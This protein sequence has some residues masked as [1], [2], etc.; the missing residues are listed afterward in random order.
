MNK[1]ENY[2]FKKNNSGTPF[3]DKQKSK[4]SKTEWAGMS[5]KQLFHAIERAE[6]QY[7]KDIHSKIPRDQAK[8][9][10]DMLSEIVHKIDQEPSNDIGDLR[11][12]LHG[13][14]DRID[15]VMHRTFMNPSE[16]EFRLLQNLERLKT[17]F[18]Y[19]D[20]AEPQELHHSNI[21]TLNSLPGNGKVMEGMTQ[22]RVLEQVQDGTGSGGENCGFHALKNSLLMLSENDPNQLHLLFNDRDV[23]LKFYNTY[24]LPFVKEKVIGSRDATQP[25]L[26]DILQ[27]EPASFK[28]PFADPIGAI[29]QDP[30]TKNKI[31]IFQMSTT[32]GGSDGVPVLGFTGN[33]QALDGLKLVRFAK[34]PG[35]S[36]LTM[37]FGDEM[38]GHWYALQVNKDALNEISFIGSDSM[39]NHHEIFGDRSA[40]GQ[41]AALIKGHIENSEDLLKSI[42]AYV[43]DSLSIYSGWFAPDQTIEQSNALALLDDTPNLLL[44]SEESPKGSKKEMILSNCLTAYKIIQ[45]GNW[46]FSSDLWIYERIS[47]L[48]VLVNFYIS[49]LPINDPYVPKLQEIRREIQFQKNGNIISEIIE[50]AVADI[51]QKRT[52]LSARDCDQVSSVFTHL[53]T[54]Y[55]ERKQL[56]KI[57][58]KT[59]RENAMNLLV[60]GGIEPGF[61]TGTTPNEAERSLTHKIHMVLLTYQKAK[62]LNRLDDLMKKIYQGDVCLTARVGRI[63]EFQAELEGM[64]MNEDEGPAG[65]LNDGPMLAISEFL[66][67]LTEESSDPIEDVKNV[68][69]NEIRQLADLQSLANQFATYC[70]GY[71]AAP[72][73]HLLKKQG[74]ISDI[75]NIDWIDA[76]SKIIKRPEFSIWFELGKAQAIHDLNL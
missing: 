3:F 44:A 21:E 57:Q 54:L 61:A 74:V 36:S 37:I 62:K 72:L 35:P 59:K 50:N 1:Y 19:V 18:H 69:I 31:A 45:E 76:V 9:I 34:Q 53:L 64:R 63:E 39:D 13:K 67:Q 52:Q 26:R 66:Q 4:N 58:D 70:S 71:Q 33:F 55:T 6:N 7:I 68:Q 51:N 27:Q 41:L 24:C 30:G 60:P 29:L 16:E 11:S 42:Y 40:F 49:R 56:S 12:I 75:D 32:T 43:G 47:D 8:P 25:I 2:N 20:Q 46:L 15:E 23:F 65:R 17:Q 48:E 14:I 10:V 5:I 38:S 73:L 22:I 28:G